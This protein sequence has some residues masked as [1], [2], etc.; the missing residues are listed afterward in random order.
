MKGVGVIKYLS[1]YV[2][3]KTL[4]Q[5]YKMYV[6][7]HFNFCDVIYH[8]PEKQD[9]LT[10]KMNLPF[11]MEKI[12]KGKFHASLAVT[13]TWKTTSREIMTNL[14]GSPFG[15]ADGVVVLC[16]FSKFRMVL[17]QITLRNPSSSS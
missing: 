11:W 5:I 7:P 12:E 13:G 9:L 3:V 6:R 4:D 2:P 17:Y 16:N 15:K 8:L 10:S 1:Y 14:V